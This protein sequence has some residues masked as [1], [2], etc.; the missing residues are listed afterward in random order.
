ME[1]S[2]HGTHLISQ[3]VERVCDCLVSILVAGSKDCD[4]QK[5]L[6]QMATY[7]RGGRDD[8]NDGQFEFQIAQRLAE[9][10]CALSEKFEVCRQFVQDQSEHFLFNYIGRILD[11]KRLENL[12]SRN[13]KR[14]RQEN[15]E[16]S[17]AQALAMLELFNDDFSLE[18]E[19][20]NDFGATMRLKSKTRAK[21]RVVWQFGQN[22][23]ST[24][25]MVSAKNSV[26]IKVAALGDGLL[27]DFNDESSN[28]MY[29]V[30]LETEGMKCLRMLRG[31]VSAISNESSPNDS[32][33]ERTSSFIIGTVIKHIL[34]IVKSMKYY[35]QTCNLGDAANEA[36]ITRT[37]ISE[38]LSTYTELFIALL[39]WILR[40]RR[41]E[42]SPKWNSFLDR[43]YD[44][45]ICPILKRQ[46]VDFTS[47]LREL[48]AMSG[49]ENQTT[50]PTT[51]SLPG[52]S[53]YLNDVFTSV[54]RRSRQLFTARFRNRSI[55]NSLHEVVR[56]SDD[57]DEANISRIVG[58][59]FATEFSP[60]ALT[61]TYDNP[62]QQEIDEDFWLAE[63]AMSTRAGNINELK[64]VR[65]E[66]LNMFISPYL[67]RKQVP[68]EEKR[69]LLR[70]L[71]SMFSTAANEKAMNFSSADIEVLSLCAK[72]ICFCLVQ[73]LT[74]PNVD[75]D[76]VS[77][78]YACSTNFANIGIVQRHG[79]SQD[80]LINWT[81][82]V[83]EQEIDKTSDQVSQEALSASFLWTFFRWLQKLGY[84]MI[85]TD[86]R[87]AKKLELFRQKCIT[88]SR[89]KATGTDPC[90][91]HS[92]LRDGRHFE[93]WDRLLSQFEEMLFPSATRINTNIVNTY[94]KR[95]DS[96]N[97]GAESIKPWTPPASVKR[98]AKEF[99]AEVVAVS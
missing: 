28:A 93:S 44:K 16:K 69:K 96:V 36:D 6:K 55:Q 7:I 73:C 86:V 95:N 70:M 54:I 52:C 32:S 61:S 83:M 60:S 5:V 71:V 27:N 14:I 53:Q 56:N 84:F 29:P 66:F 15:G 91:I 64:R 42:G 63:K 77:V 46:K 75:T 79:E 47:S 12:P 80:T 81:R 30:S 94:E 31:V 76:L 67:C 41:H 72:N 20:Y 65:L 85:A 26:S 38:L 43:A 2:M 59:S 23:G 19:N 39:A 4:V 24:F 68:M 89:K 10:L 9:E 88:D 11:A 87:E 18:T 25:K 99:I 1:M 97:V 40:E 48:L 45:V 92:L 33:F 58:T 98:A 17:A 49:A 37:R 57:A 8:S 74:K 82:A 35:D 21:I 3:D 34:R 78:V 90:S 62:L 22:L 13:L 50:E 51:P